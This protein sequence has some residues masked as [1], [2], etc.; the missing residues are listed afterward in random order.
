M[1]PTT[2]YIE[3]T[4]GSSNITETFVQRYTGNDIRSA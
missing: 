3:H 1:D 2:G 4:I